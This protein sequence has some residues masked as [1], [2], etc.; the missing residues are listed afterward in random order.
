MPPKTT[1]DPAK[2]AAKRAKTV[3]WNLANLRAEEVKAA[4]AAQDAQQSSASS[5]VENQ[6]SRERLL[7]Q[8]VSTSMPQSQLPATESAPPPAQGPPDAPRPTWPQDR[9]PTREEFSAVMA[10]MEPVPS[11]STPSSAGTSQP[12]SSAGRQFHIPFSAE[13]KS[14]MAEFLRQRQQQKP[15]SNAELM[16]SAPSD[17]ATGN[18]E[19]ATLH[20]IQQLIKIQTDN[21]HRAEAAL[22][23]KEAKRQISVPPAIATAAPIVRRQALI[24]QM[25]LVIKEK[26]N[27]D[28]AAFKVLEHWA[29]ASAEKQNWSEASK[30]LQMLCQQDP[31]ISSQLQ[32]LIS[33]TI[34]TCDALFWHRPSQSTGRHQAAQQTSTA[35]PDN[36]SDAAAMA[37]LK[38]VMAAGQTPATTV[39]PKAAAATKKPPTATVKHNGTPCVWCSKFGFE[40]TPCYSKERMEKQGP[41]TTTIE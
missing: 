39:A 18:L 1:E 7:L 41:V 10:L 15:P 5:Q 34:S 35:A 40:A 31:A 9:I 13:Q 33:Y 6:V 23:I 37:F 20:A 14:P 11:I 16:Q 27:D 12:S 19:S 26:L 32:E 28:V 2:R 36:N 25:I 21:S 38:R 3:Q 17:S 8:S 29:K 22:L 24:Q 30:F 4:Q